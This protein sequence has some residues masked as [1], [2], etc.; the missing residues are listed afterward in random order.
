MTSNETY[1]EKKRPR[2]IAPAFASK[3][4]FY[5]RNFR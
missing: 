3:D 1:K 2:N 4:G 5:N